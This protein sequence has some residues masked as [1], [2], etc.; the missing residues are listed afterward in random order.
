MT[1]A[2]ANELV[3]NLW[4]CVRSNRSNTPIFDNFCLMKA[5]IRSNRVPSKQHFSTHEYINEVL[6]RLS[7]VFIGRYSR[8]LL[9]N[10]QNAS[11]WIGVGTGVGRM[12]LDFTFRKSIF[13][14][15]VSVLLANT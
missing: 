15:L 7:N 3:E 2:N 12:I 10:V 8:F 6:P 5:L 13:I 11:N 9:Y 14:Y 4:K 1:C